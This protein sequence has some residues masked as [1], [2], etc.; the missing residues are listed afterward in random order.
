LA[1]TPGKKPTFY[2]LTQPRFAVNIEANKR[3]ITLR[4]L[5]ANFNRCRALSNPVFFARVLDQGIILWDRLWGGIEIP[6]QIPHHEIS[7]I[8]AGL[9]RMGGMG[10]FF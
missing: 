4:S 2:D 9:V 10:G 8:D 5:S 3:E 6:H 7:L 1:F